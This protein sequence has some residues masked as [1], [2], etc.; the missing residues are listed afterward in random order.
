MVHDD[1]TGHALNDPVRDVGA[2]A[3][4]P[5]TNANPA[6]GPVTTEDDTL[7]SIRVSHGSLEEADYA[8]MVGT[9]EDETLGGAERFLDRQLGGVLIASYEA[10]SYPGPFEGNALFIRPHPDVTMRTAP[11]GAYVVGLGRSVDLTRSRVAPRR[12][13]GSHRPRPQPGELARRRDHRRRA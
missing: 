6:T 4:A 11:P 8:V 10:G 9:Y 7:V 13:P 1:V 12:C 3:S 5:G 2:G